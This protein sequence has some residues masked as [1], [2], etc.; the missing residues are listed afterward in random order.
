MLDTKWQRSVESA[1]K[2]TP[3]SKRQCGPKEAGSLESKETRIA[4][5]NEVIKRH[6]FVEFIDKSD[7]NGKMTTMLENG[8]RAA[9]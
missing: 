3:G 1:I 4:K 5:A 2:D 7:E 9:H 6:L 8:A